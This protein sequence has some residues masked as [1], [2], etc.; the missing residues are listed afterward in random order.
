MRRQ[1]DI[2][3]S[4]QMCTVKLDGIGRA[5]YGMGEV[6]LMSVY[7]WATGNMNALHVACVFVQYILISAFLINICLLSQINNFCK[8]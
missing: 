5:D 6:M 3:Q 8:G 1:F 2:C 4:C 7:E